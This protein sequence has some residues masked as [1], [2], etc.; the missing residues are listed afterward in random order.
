MLLEGVVLLYG[1]AILLVGKMWAPELLPLGWIAPAFFVIYESIFAGLFSRYG[2]MTPQKMMLTSMIL[3]GV[4]FLGVAIMMFLWVM[5]ELPDK[6]AFLMYLL[7]YYILS[8]I[9]ESWSVSAYNREKGAKG[10][11]GA[12]EKSE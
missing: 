9:F 7:G 2:K 12:K 3:R 1:A 5:L 10:A 4:K 11:K 6:G 8:S